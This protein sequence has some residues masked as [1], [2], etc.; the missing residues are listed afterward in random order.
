[1]T[2]YAHGTHLNPIPQ[3]PGHKATVVEKAI[4]EPTFSWNVLALITEGL[5]A[6]SYAATVVVG[7]NGISNG[8]DNPFKPV[9]HGQI[10]MTKLYIVHRFGL[11]PVSAI[12]HDRDPSVNILDHAIYPYVSDIYG[13]QPLVDPH[14]S[15]VAVAN[16]VVSDQETH[17][18]FIQL[19]PSI[20]Q[21]ARLRVN[22]MKP[23]D[24]LI[25]PS[26]HGNLLMSNGRI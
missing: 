16:A 4:V 8:T 10:V 21:P 5:E 2:R 7:K 26:S 17:C 13:C 18:A 22:F 24:L 6:T 19:P 12:D 3:L 1:M 14:G 25:S 9:T 11:V 23:E 15:P 20:S